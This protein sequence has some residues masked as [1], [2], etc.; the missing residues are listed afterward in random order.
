[1][2]PANQVGNGENYLS[3]IPDRGA[4]LILINHQPSALIYLLTRPLRNA[5][6]VRMTPRSSARPFRR[7]M[8]E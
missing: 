2:K 1:M 5:S 7:P 3:L 6:T 4:K 8:N